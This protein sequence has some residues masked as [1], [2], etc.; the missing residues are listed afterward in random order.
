M[1]R[2]LGFFPRRVM[3]FMG[4]LL[5]VFATAAIA[6]DGLLGKLGLSIENSERALKLVD[7]LIMS[8]KLD[9]A[10]L[11]GARSKL[12][13]IQND[14]SGARQLI[15][16]RIVVLDKE[17]VE[18]GP[19]P[20]ENASPEP[21]L[22]SLRRQELNTER[23]S[24]AILS[25]RSAE[26]VERTT[27]SIEIIAEKR[28]DAFTTALFERTK[29]TPSLFDS[30]VNAS[31]S[32]IVSVQ[33]LTLDWLNYVK[34]AK[35][36][37]ALLSTM[38]ALIAAILLVRVARYL[39]SRAFDITSEQVD[40]T[41]FAKLARAFWR[42]VLP[43]I[44]FVVF[45]GAS[46]ALYA[47]F[48]IFTSKVGSIVQA[49]FPILAGIF[50]V[51]NLALAVF[52]PN[53]GVWR[54]IAMPDQSA[55]W[56]VILIVAIAVVNGVDIFVGRLNNVAAAPLSLTILKSL[57]AALLI[58][59][60]LLA[61]S[62][63]R[64]RETEIDGQVRIVGWSRWV[65]IPIGLIG[66][67]IIVT[68]FSGYIGLARFVSQQVIITG[69]ILAT[70][71]IGVLIGREIGREGVF[72]NT[73][74]GR[75]LAE[76]LSLQS[77]T[78][79]RIGVF[80]SLATTFAVVAIGLPLLSLQ[81]GSRTED[82]LFWSWKVFNGFEI[83][84]VKLSLSALMIGIT[85]FVFVFLLSRLFGTWLDTAVLTRSRMDSGVRDSVKAGVGYVGV[86]L[87]LL[88]AVTS[89]GVDL[90]SLAIVAGALSLGIG[91]G[92]QNIVSN[93]VSGLILLIERPIKV[94]DW[95]EV[96]GMSGFVRKISV[97]AT[98]IET[99]NRQSVIVPN[100]ELINGQVGNWTHKNR[101]GRI[102]IPVGVS[103]SSNVREV[104]EI[105]YRIARGQTGVLKHPEPFVLFSG[106]GDSSLDFELR[107]HIG[108][109]T[110]QPFILT[111]IRFSIMDEFKK[112]GI[113]IP[114]PQRDVHMRTET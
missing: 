10:G 47:S 84:N 23:T 71:Y 37:P 41:Y 77:E 22:V 102:D 58:G 9:D 3:A 49:L 81:W 61:L 1:K 73:L 65:A 103:Y 83:G 74:F 35:Y 18:I 57:V 31:R 62:F 55:R 75:F 114:F 76:K 78:V 30:G 60:L 66:I 100:S 101:G 50:L 28:R 6:Q 20:K 2:H 94:G 112:S 64:G 113:E 87:A 82:I 39:F 43:S 59:L 54:L 67:A 53:D 40:P 80:F 13:G 24:L 108:D 98:E 91:F 17:L 46:Y 72:V 86:G 106:F 11:V 29:L 34:R 14:M 42:A 105:L 97:R 79:D 45:F 15:L 8:G 110:R 107:V 92:L 25:T 56:T 93:F 16:D 63:V 12:E 95:V 33:R 90:S 38:A 88:F 19:A 70:L 4:I 48:G 5:V 96:G 21:E 85:T 99:F 104:E 89:A 36:W 52:S 27:A 32:N 7:R 44:A 51:R 68:A 111:D 26:V 109:I 69:A